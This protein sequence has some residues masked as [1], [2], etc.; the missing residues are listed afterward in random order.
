[1]YAVCFR[2]KNVPV[3]FV[4]EVVPGSEKFDIK[5][6]CN[7]LLKLGHLAN[8]YQYHALSLLSPAGKQLTTHWYD[9]WPFEA[10]LGHDYDWPNVISLQPLLHHASSTIISILT[11]GSSWVPQVTDPNSSCLFH[12]LTKFSAG[13]SPDAHLVDSDTNWLVR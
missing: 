7:Q 11:H 1:M 12:I 6:Y 3:V 9:G 8:Y 5:A 10:L 2:G 4:Q 13:T